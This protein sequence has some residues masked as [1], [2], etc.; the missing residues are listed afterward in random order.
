MAD[1]TLKQGVATQIQQVAPGITK[2][3]DVTDHA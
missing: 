2:V 3:L 1:V